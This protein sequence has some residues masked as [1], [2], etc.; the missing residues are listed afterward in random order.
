[1][2]EKHALV[3]YTHYSKEQGVSTRVC[4]VDF[5]RMNEDDRARWKRFLIARIR[6]PTTRNK[7]MISIQNDSFWLRWFGFT[8]P[9]EDEEEWQQPACMV[10]LNFGVIPNVPIRRMYLLRCEDVDDEYL[11]NE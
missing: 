2:A 11:D 10:T 7:G 3:I 5:E 8:D 4:R 1:M 9:L 6:Y